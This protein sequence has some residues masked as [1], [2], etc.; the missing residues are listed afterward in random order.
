MPNIVY[1]LTNPAMPGMVKIGMTDR[2]DVQ[3]RMNELYSTGVPLP[4]ECV[5]AREIE[6]REATEIENALHIAFGPYRVSDSREF[7]GIQ[8]EQAEALL[9]VMHG[10]DVT[11]RV[12]EQEAE[13]KP[14]D[15]EAVKRWTQTSEQEFLD[16][17]D[18][19]GVR[20]FDRVLQ[21]GKQE[22]MQIKWGRVGFSLNAVS[23]GTLVVICYGYA[24]HSKKFG[25]SIYTDFSLMTKKTS[26]PQQVID[27]L[28]NGAQATGLFESAGGSGNEFRCRIDRRLEETDISVLTEWLDTVIKRIREFEAVSPDQGAGLQ[29]N[30]PI[31]GN[32]PGDLRK[33]W[34]P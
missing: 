8:P 21:L 28:G 23:N 18:A 11:P 29:K 13:L 7:F 30:N 20:V 17:L 1:V 3:R 31:G 9:Q 15:I 6:D 24:P 34:V 25:Q 32:G 33:R 27:D 16:S 19:N 10:K 14:A 26:L 12:N 2:P 4:F 5:I 22:G